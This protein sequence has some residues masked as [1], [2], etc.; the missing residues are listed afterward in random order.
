MFIFCKPGVFGL[1][2]GR[3]YITGLVQ[4]VMEWSHDFAYAVGLIATDGCLSKDGRHIDLTSKDLEQIQ[5]FKSILKASN[6]IGI[7]HCGKG[8]EKAYYRI[9]LGNVKLYRFL[10]SLGITPH[11]SKTIGKLNIPDKYFGDFLRGC[12]DGDGCTYSYWDKRWKSSFMLYT[13]FV[14]ASEAFLMWLKGKIYELYGITGKINYSEKSKYQLKYA[15]GSSLVLLSKIY[16]LDKLVCLKRKRFKIDQSLG[17]IAEQ[18]RV[19]K[20]VYT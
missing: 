1:V 14:S 5:N 3:Q 13:V 16:Y 10:M 17:I 11:K 7:K 20:L 6:K 4:W 12:F 15:K 19:V 18:A 9:Q 2:K 8:I